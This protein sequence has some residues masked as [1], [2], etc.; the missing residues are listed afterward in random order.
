MIL[1]QN[2]LCNKDELIKFIQTRKSEMELIRDLQKHIIYI[3]S[4]IMSI[5][6]VYDFIKQSIFLNEHCS[7]RSFRQLL[8]SIDS[9]Y[10]F[11]RLSFKEV[12]FLITTIEIKE[13][14]KKLF[15]PNELIFIFEQKRILLLLLDENLITI[16]SLIEEVCSGESFFFYFFPEIKE[17]DFEEFSS[18]INGKFSHLE[19]LPDIDEHNELRRINENE[20]EIT[21]YIRKNDVEKFRELLSLENNNNSLFELSLENFK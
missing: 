17:N 7:K 16:Q 19:P 12:E 15:T 13:K 1:M 18:K 20:A 8:F 11:R 6:M 21:K 3:E 5:E 14:I 9:L 4:E 10:T 2:V